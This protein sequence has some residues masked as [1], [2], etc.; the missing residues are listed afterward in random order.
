MHGYAFRQAL[1]A[2]ASKDSYK[3][4]SSLSAGDRGVF[5]Q[6][7]LPY[8]WWRDPTRDICC[9][10]IQIESFLQSVFELKSHEE[11]EPVGTCPTR[12][13]P[14]G[15]RSNLPA[16]DR[17]VRGVLRQMDC[18]LEMVIRHQRIRDPLRNGDLF[19]ERSEKY[20]IGPLI[21]W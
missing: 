12:L 5:Q 9:R 4:T 20:S 19:I 13:W 16:W 6:R 1:L 18:D 2:I 15:D 17:A 3:S 10:N 11:V 14:R 21:R 7:Y 8:T